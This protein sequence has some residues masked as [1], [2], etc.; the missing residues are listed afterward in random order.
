MP[1]EPALEG[2]SLLVLG[3]VRLGF[4]LKSF[5]ESDVLGA[6]VFFTAPYFNIGIFS[7]N[8]KDNDYSNKMG[9]PGDLR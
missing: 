5:K 7:M 2:L 8:W 4:L 9:G 3:P 6:P 1:Q